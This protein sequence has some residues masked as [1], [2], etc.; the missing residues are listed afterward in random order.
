MLHI[1]VMQ[2]VL[3][4]SEKRYSDDGEP[5]NRTAGKPIYDCI[6]GAKIADVMLN[7]CSSLF[8][9]EQNSAPEV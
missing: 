9:L 7:S 1:I 3:N 8:W 4:N 6:I 5:N 2:L